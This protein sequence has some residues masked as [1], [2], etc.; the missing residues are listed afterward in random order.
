[1][2]LSLHDFLKREIRRMLTGI[3]KDKFGNIYSLIIKEVEKSII[4]LVLEETKFNYL[5]ASKLLGISRST[6]YRKIDFFG[7]YGKKS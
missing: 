1:M 2:S 5:L 4:I 7:I 3:E 6:L